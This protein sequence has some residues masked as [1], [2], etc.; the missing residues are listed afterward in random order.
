MA[1]CCPGFAAERKEG[2]T[3]GHEAAVA[4]SVRAC[5]AA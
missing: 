4:A 1:V 5:W 2:A 3:C